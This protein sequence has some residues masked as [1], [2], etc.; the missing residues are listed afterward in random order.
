[1]P[2]P[3]RKTYTGGCLCGWIKFEAIGPALKPHTC[4]CKMCQRHTGALTA[5]WVEFPAEDVSWT[6]EG[7]RPSTWRSSDYSSRS[8][9]PKCGSSIGAIDD[10]PVVALLLGTF[11][12]TNHK[13]LAAT[14]HSFKGARP[15]WWGV[16][17]RNDE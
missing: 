5:A 9:C 15:R 7:G 16:E 2:M 3:V 10:N 17:V 4:S 6:G 8:F 11:D 12:K 13:E 1:M 14:A